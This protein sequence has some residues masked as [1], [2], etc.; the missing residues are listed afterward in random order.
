MAHINFG[1]MPYLIAGDTYRLELY[2]EGT[3]TGTPTWQLY[4]NGQ[5][6][7]GVTNGTNMGSNLWRFDIATPAN[8]TPGKSARIRITAN[9]DAAPYTADLHSSVASPVKLVEREVT[10]RHQQN[11]L[12]ETNKYADVTITDP[13]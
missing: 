13:T 11:A 2:F 10:Y 8:S 7:V 5:E 4:V 6:V 12:D 1:L 3:V 9:V